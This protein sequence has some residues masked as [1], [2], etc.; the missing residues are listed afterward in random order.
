MRR[1][2]P[3][4]PRVTGGRKMRHDRSSVQSRKLCC[5]VCRCVLAIAFLCTL[6]RRETASP[7]TRPGDD[8]FPSAA[9]KVDAGRRPRRGTARAAPPASRV[10][11]DGVAAERH[12][13]PPQWR[14]ARPRAAWGRLPLMA[15]PPP[16]VS[17]VPGG[18][19]AAERHAAPPQWRAARP[20]AAWG[21]LPVMAKPPPPVRL[22]PGGGVAAER[23]AAPPQWRAARR[24]PPQGGAARRAPPQERAAPRGRAPPPQARAGAAAA[25]GVVGRLE[26]ARRGG[27]GEER[28][29][30][31]HG[32]GLAHARRGRHARVLQGHAGTGH[33]GQRCFSTGKSFAPY[34]ALGVV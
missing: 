10:P 31:A 8:V 19:V 32:A 25:G 23:H 18:G 3:L 20:R 16:S 14:A 13:A 26:G 30:V 28:H 5:V 27:R 6:F 24:A 4:E 1:E 22:V 12:A 9:G 21:R 29:D 33:M 34:M 15:K 11:G 2:A 17:L 7:S